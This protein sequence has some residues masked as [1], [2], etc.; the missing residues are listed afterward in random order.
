MLFLSHP[1]PL[2]APLDLCCLE[3]TLARPRFDV[4]GRD[5]VS[6]QP[7]LLASSL[8]NYLEFI[9]LKGRARGSAVTLPNQ[10]NE[11]SRRTSTQQWT[12]RLHKKMQQHKRLD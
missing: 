5:P 8:N 12:C 2:I 11:L 10:T 6:E 3:Q 9:V 1:S 4:K 7:M